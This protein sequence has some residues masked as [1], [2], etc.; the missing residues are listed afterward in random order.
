[1]K[2]KIFPVVSMHDKFIY[3]YLS[4]NNSKVIS[5]QCLHKAG[6]ARALCISLAF[7]HH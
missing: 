5:I 3:K 2:K 1:M 6:I 7:E 4:D